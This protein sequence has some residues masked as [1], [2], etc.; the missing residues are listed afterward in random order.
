VRGLGLLLGVE[1]SVPAAPIVAA[2]RERGLLILTAGE[3]VLRFVPPLIIEEREVDTALE[4]LEE[5]FEA[6]K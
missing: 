5:A 2:A 3:R 1:L 4:I 6:C